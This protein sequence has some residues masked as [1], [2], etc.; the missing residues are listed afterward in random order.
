[1]ALLY[2]LAGFSEDK[3]AP[4]ITAS[5]SFKLTGYTQFFGTIQETGVDSAAVR[6]ARFSLSGEII[7]NLKAKVAI[8]LVRSPV[9]V[10]VQLDAAFSEALNLRFGQFLVPFGVE[11]AVSTADLDT[12]NRSQPVDKLAPGRDVG[13]LGRDVGVALTGKISLFDY[14]VGLFNGTG[15]NKADT[16]DKKDF[17]G[18]LGVRPLD[19]L[20]VGASLY[21]GSYNTAVGTPSNRRDRTGLDAEAT[22]GDLSLKGEYVWAID[23]ATDKRGWFAQAGWFVLPK[24]IQVLAKFDSFDK[25]VSAVSDRMSLYTFGLNWF[26]AERTKLQVNFESLRTE[27]GRMANQTL[28]VQ[29]QAGF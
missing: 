12:I 22:F 24:T 21:K 27:S 3:P 28:L 29:F 2:P 20:S 9:L 25:N 7:K 5:K 19:F 14:T 15:A 11:S 17:A 23:D 26:F 8:D 1:M 4:A 18:R 16:N 6:R 10:E 13:T